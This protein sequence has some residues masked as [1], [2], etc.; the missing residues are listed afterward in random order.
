ME[1]ITLELI[2]KQCVMDADDDRFDNLLMLYRDAAV[3][4]VLTYTGWSEAG[5]VEKW[6]R[7]PAPFI[8]A[9][10]MIV[11]SMF[12]HREGETP[13]SMSDIARPLLRLL[14]PYINPDKL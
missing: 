10:L 14:N 13:N 2:K 4:K 5:L 7:V 11:A 8:T 3:E 12:A 6:G 9:V 1:S